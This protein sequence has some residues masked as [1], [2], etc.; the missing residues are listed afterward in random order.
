MR[1]LILRRE[2]HRHTKGNFDQTL[3]PILFLL[4]NALIFTIFIIIPAFQGLR[5]SLFDWG[6]F[7]K[8]RYIGLAN[9]RAMLADEV[10]L[11]TLQNTLVYSLFVVPLLVAAAL[12]L[13]L[14][15]HRNTVRW[16]NAFRSVFYIP[17][18]LSMITVGISWRFILG[19]DMGIVNYLIEGFVGGSVNW[20]TN[21]TL[22]MGS[23]I[24]VS[25]WAGAGYYMV[26]LIGGLQAIP[27]ELYEAAMIDGARSWDRFRFVTLPMLKN[28]LLVAVVL[29][30]ITSFKA[31][32]LIAVMTQGGPGYATK[33][34][35]QQVYQA[36]FVEDRLG[37]ASAMSI[38]LLLLIS[39]FTLIQFKASGK[40]Q[41]NE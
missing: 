2:R 38:V 7:S 33:F 12:I 19:D 4:P 34:I 6:A 23:V 35:V 29:A 21:E 13:A 8:P 11:R 14:L 1:G 16:V 39:G 32:E 25:V 3:A 41:E 28:T 24:F 37:Y 36:A 22:A 5:M 27:S 17:S 9:F 31:Y 26:I 30:T 15:L 18:L 20:L 10:F 40:E